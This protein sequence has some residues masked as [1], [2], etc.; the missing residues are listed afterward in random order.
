MAMILKL[1]GLEAY[2]IDLY[3]S[4]PGNAA[5][6]AAGPV[7]GMRQTGW[8]ISADPRSQIINVCVNGGEIKSWQW[9]D[10]EEL[11]PGRDYELETEDGMIIGGF[12]TMCADTIGLPEDHPYYNY[13]AGQIMPSSVWTLRHRPEDTTGG[14]VYLW[15]FQPSENAYTDEEKASAASLNPWVMIYPASRPGATDRQYADGTEELRSLA[16]EPLG[17]GAAEGGYSQLTARKCCGNT[18]GQR[19]LR[20][21]DC[22]VKDGGYSY[23]ADPGLESEYSAMTFG[24]PDCGRG[25]LEP[26]TSYGDYWSCMFDRTGGY[27]RNGVSIISDVG[28]WAGVGYTWTILD[29]RPGVEQKYALL[30][31]GVSFSASS[32]DSAR[33][34]RYADDA[35]SSASTAY[36]V[37]A[38]SLDVGEE[39]MSDYTKCPTCGATCTIGGIGD[40]RDSDKV[41]TMHFDPIEKKLE[42]QNRIL[43]RALRFY[44]TKEAYKIPAIEFPGETARYALKEEKEVK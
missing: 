17:G 1:E 21:G 31:G 13:K 32:G 20:D 22:K 36:G 26:Y 42:K 28:A 11:I 3:G 43:R 18:P 5:G 39:Q 10:S 15:N 40:F 16:V 4:A 9:D 2:D 35:L 12:H 37:R 14:Y 25:R 8:Y 33:G 41:C 34:V 24:T 38:A 30:A 7:E 6:N 19:L 23:N 29:R 27:V 44:A